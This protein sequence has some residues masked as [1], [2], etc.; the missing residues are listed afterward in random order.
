[1]KTT[2]RLPLL[3]LSL[4][5]ACAVFGPF[6]IGEDRLSPQVDRVLLEPSFSHPFGT[7]SLGRDLLLR[8]VRGA[9]V[10]LLVGIFGSLAAVSLGV[11]LGVTAGWKGGWVDR[12]LMRL[13]EIFQSVPSFALVAVFTMAFQT[14]FL[15]DSDQVWG[16]MFSLILAL[17]LTHWMSV[18]RVTRGLVMQAK[19]QPFVEAARA[20]GATQGHILRR[21]VGP[22]IAAPIAVLLGMQIPSQILYESFMSFIGLGVQAPETSWGLLVQEG[23][24]SLS[25]YPHLILFPSLVLF[26]TVW[27][28]H[29]L[30]PKRLTD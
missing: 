27:S 23:W 1:M 9:R 21:H 7:D 2:P 30:G 11:L 3:W 24:R 15:S 25:T 29:L 16:V 8:T 5:V 17:M 22:Q 20:L 28:L 13:T 26:L 14:Q 6:V 4:M 19:V 10:S 12:I 18:A